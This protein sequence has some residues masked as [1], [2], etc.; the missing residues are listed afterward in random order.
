[1]TAPNGPAQQSCIRS[2]MAE[3]GLVASEITVAECHGTGTALGD[4]IEV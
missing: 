4:P 2:S 1:M 3:S